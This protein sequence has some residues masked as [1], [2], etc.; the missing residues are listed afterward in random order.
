MPAAA[1]HEAVSIRRGLQALGEDSSKAWADISNVNVLC[2]RC[3]SIDWETTRFYLS[4][5]DDYASY[6]K[7]PLYGQQAQ[8]QQIRGAAHSGCHLCTLILTCLTSMRYRTSIGFDPKPYGLCEIQDETPIQVYV[9][10]MSLAWY[11]SP[12]WLTVGIANHNSLEGWLDLSTPIVGS[13]PADEGPSFS[14][15]SPS[16]IAQYWLHDCLKSHTRCE[17]RVTRLPKRIIDVT[18]SKLF[19]KEDMRDA[20]YA[21]LSYKIGNVALFTTTAETLEERKAG[22]SVQQLVQTA[23]DAV[24]WTRKLGLPYLWIDSLCILQDSLT[25]W[26]IELSTMADIYENATVVIAAAA[27]ETANESCLP[28]MN[29]LAKV[30]CEPTPGIFI[31][32]DFERDRW[33]HSKG[34]LDTR[35][36]TFQEVQ[37]GTR[38]LR[39]GSEEIAWQCRTCK[40]R[41][42]MPTKEREHDVQSAFFTLGS[43]ALDTRK[44]LHSDLF[45]VWYVLA[46]D[47]SSR[48][49][50]FTADRLPA[51]SGMAKLFQ[52]QLQATYLCGL[53][54]EDLY[55]GLLWRSTHT[56]HF[57]MYRAPSWSWVSVEDNQLVWL[58][59]LL[60]TDTKEWVYE[61]HEASV[62]VPGMN[63]YGRVTRGKLVLS[64]FV[65]PLPSY[66]CGDDNDRGSFKWEWPLLM[67][68]VEIVPSPGSLLLRLHKKFCLVLEPVGNKTYR[69]IGSLVTGSEFSG[70]QH[71]GHSQRGW[72]LSI[73]TSIVE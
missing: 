26:E 23:Q 40:R 31:L 37:L 25:D 33:I 51:F 66:L 3:A 35:A 45:R 44:T 48:D 8:L 73:C 18:G 49:I 56:G 43:R 67:P 10:V 20:P 1:R 53:W 28:S 17:Q 12:T 72:K 70:Q 60:Q 65:A 64:G 36:W 34:A 47:F 55:H 16:D 38:V 27:A 29:K 50:S 2:S 59:D 68:D 30:A 57:T 32:P 69:R 22:F 46:R 21:A 63:P 13:L 4:V 9:E 41:E 15:S 11:S 42:I 14:A 54:E 39:V 71:I 58:W 24:W 62:V 7:I 5:V 6:P 61:I 19:L 52:S